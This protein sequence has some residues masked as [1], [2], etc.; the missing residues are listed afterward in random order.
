[1]QHDIFSAIVTV[2]LTNASVINREF[3]EII[4]L[5]F[6]LE[7]VFTKLTNIY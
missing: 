4:M 5:F 3:P 7:D 6:I 1:M 2:S